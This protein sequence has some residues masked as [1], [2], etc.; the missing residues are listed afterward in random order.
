MS[1]KNT[2]QALS[3]HDRAFLIREAVRNGIT[4]INSIR[5]T[6]EHRFDGTKDN[7]PTEDEYI[8]QRAKE[9]ISITI[10]SHQFLFLN[11]R[12]QSIAQACCWRVLLQKANV[13]NPPDKTAKRGV[14]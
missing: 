5:D 11:Y 1:I 6:W 12:P 9:K 14:F 2:W 3:M 10:F 4:D 8:A 7:V 13:I